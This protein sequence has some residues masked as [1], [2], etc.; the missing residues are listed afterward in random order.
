MRESSIEEAVSMN[1]ESHHRRL[2]EM[3]E[4]IELAAEVET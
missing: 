2:D 3:L 4:R 1:L